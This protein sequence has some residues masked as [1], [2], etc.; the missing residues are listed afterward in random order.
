[1]HYALQLDDTV[2][3]PVSTVE[4]ISPPLFGILISTCLAGFAMNQLS[5]IT[6]H[7]L[8]R[9]DKVFVAVGSI[10]GFVAWACSIRVLQYYAEHYGQPA[11]L[12]STRST[13]MALYEIAGYI[14]NSTSQARPLLR[15]KLNHAGLLCSPSLEDRRTFATARSALR[16]R[17]SDL[18]RHRR[19]HRRDRL[20]RH[21]PS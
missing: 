20:H 13:G 11:S 15:S 16:R 7:S 6:T 21:C 4:A 12:V 10:C 14:A 19:V 3:Y 5:I 9:L 2:S 8:S 18:L 1:M 17:H